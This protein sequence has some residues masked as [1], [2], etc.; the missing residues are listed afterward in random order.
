VKRTE[1][2]SPREAWAREAAVLADS[3]ETGTEAAT[4]SMMRRKVLKAEPQT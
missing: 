1:T 2:Q 3:L 4:P